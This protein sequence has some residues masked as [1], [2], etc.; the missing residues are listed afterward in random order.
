MVYF[1]LSFSFLFS[2]SFTFSHSSIIST[3]NA[4]DLE[5]ECEEYEQKIEAVGGV[6]LFLGGIG[7]DGHVAF[8]EPGNELNIRQFIHLFIH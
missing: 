4:D 1:V 6:E 2:F 7:T 8:N 5:K 3:G